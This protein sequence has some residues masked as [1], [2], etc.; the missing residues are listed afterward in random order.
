MDT[1]LSELNIAVNKVASNNTAPQN[2]EDLLIGLKKEITAQ[3]KNMIDG[4]IET[5]KSKLQEKLAIS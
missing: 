2:K 5:H 4:L 3:A 1:L